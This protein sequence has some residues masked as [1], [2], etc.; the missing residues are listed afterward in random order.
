MYHWQG[1]DQGKDG[2]TAW[3]MIWLE[4]FE[5]I[6]KTPNKIGVRAEGWWWWS[7]ELEDCLYNNLVIVSDTTLLA[8]VS[9]NNR[10]ATCI[11]AI[12]L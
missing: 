9:R 2:W 5:H 11:K 8:N 4:K 1:N 6:A 10:G 12:E 3:T 7:L